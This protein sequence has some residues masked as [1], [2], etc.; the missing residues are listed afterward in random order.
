MGWGGYI[1][2]PS[3]SLGGGWKPYGGLGAPPVSSSADA[4]ATLTPKN[5]GVMS[6]CRLVASRAAFSLGIFAFA[7][8]QNAFHSRPWRCG[9]AA[10]CAWMA[11]KRASCVSQFA[12]SHQFGPFS[13]APSTT[14]DPT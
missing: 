1:A 2:L 3:L 10:G 14:L 8:T 9:A 6:R 11:A 13:A 7:S 4:A 5:F 12:S